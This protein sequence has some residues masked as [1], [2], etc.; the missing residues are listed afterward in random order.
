MKDDSRCKKRKYCDF[1]VELSND[2][3]QVERCIFCGKKVIYKKESITGRIDNKKYL[4]DH[5]RHT[6]Q[7]FGKTKK[8]F[9]EVYGKT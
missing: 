1:K 8:I 7:P 3:A 6:A 9:K 2:E 4:R 5:I